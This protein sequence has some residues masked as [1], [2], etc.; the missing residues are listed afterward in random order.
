MARR[1][2]GVSIA[3]SVN[4]TTLT[5][6]TRFGECVYCIHLRAHFALASL[7]I[8]V[9]HIKRSKRIELIHVRARHTV[10][11]VNVR[12]TVSDAKHL[13][14][15]R[16]PRFA[17][18]V[19]A[20]VR[21]VR[22][23]A[24]DALALDRPRVLGEHLVAQALDRGPH[25]AASEHVLV[26]VTTIPAFPPRAQS[27]MKQIPCLWNVAIIDEAGID[28]RT[29]WHNSKIQTR[30]VEDLCRIPNPSYVSVCD[31]H[32]TSCIKHNLGNSQ[33]HHPVEILHVG[34]VCHGL[35]ELLDAW[36]EHDGNIWEVANKTVVDS[37]FT[38]KQD[39]PLGHIKPQESADEV[40]D[41]CAPRI[42]LNGEVGRRG[43]YGQ[44]LVCLSELLLHVVYEFG[45]PLLILPSK[46]RVGARLLAPRHVFVLFPTC[47]GAPRKRIEI[48]VSQHALQ[49][50]SRY[51]TVAPRDAQTR[52]PTACSAL[53]SAHE[54]HRTVPR[55]VVI[56]QVHYQCA[57][58]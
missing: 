11:V 6:R 4:Y 27:H 3:C 7:V 15:E 26:V 54:A 5:S 49:V 12:V 21:G 43:N 58:V 1:A 22:A 30:C 39:K 33:L 29:V 23:G 45:V 14:P 16:P 48:S 10:R 51:D 35:S 53:S 2:T 9:D 31:K 52:P 41:L 40:H 55:K 57:A 36:V 20:H 46:Q 47:G 18:R 37:L 38:S 50:F 17:L 32:I 56:L 25:P 42:G 13:L 24:V 28:G 34:P 19:F 8:H 44:R